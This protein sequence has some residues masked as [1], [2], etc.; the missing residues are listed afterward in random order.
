[1]NSEKAQFNVGYKI[2]LAFYIFEGIVAMAMGLIFERMHIFA[3][4]GIGV[5]LVLSVVFLCSYLKCPKL[6]VTAYGI[7]QNIFFV[8][9]NVFFSIS[10]D[11]AQVFLYAM[12]LNTILSFVF[13]NNTLSRFQLIQSI[14]MVIASAA[15]V[16]IYT[17]SQQ[18]MLVFTFGSILLLVMNWVVMSMTIYIN[19]QYRKG[20]EQERSLDDMLKLVEAKCDD[21]Q[22][23]TR[24]KSQFL[25]NM[26]HEIRT[27]INA[28]MG[29]NEMILR[30]SKEPGIRNYASETMTAAEALLEIINDIL[31]IT[32][33]ET[34]KLV[35]YPNEYSVQSLINDIYNLIQF[36]AYNKE[37]ELNFIIDENIP[38]KLIGD[39]IRLK[40]VIMNL[41]SNA[42][43]YTHTG[44][45]TFEAKYLG[46]GKLSFSVK[47]TGIGIKREDINRLF[48]AFERF[49]QNKNR[50][51]EG[52]GLGLNIA[53]SLLKMFG[54]KLNVISK[55]G[56][57]SIFSFEISQEI[58]DPTPVGK[59]K[60]KTRESGRKAYFTKF[61]APDAKILV[62][63]DN[64]MNRKVFINLLK[65]TKISI[66][67]AESG[68]ECLSMVQKNVYDII[69][70]DH[71]MPEMDGIQ[72]FDAMKEMDNN[73]SKDAPVFILTANAV[74]GAK[75][76]YIE[77]GFDGYLS[78]PVD[79]EKLEKMVISVLG[80][81]DEVYQSEAE[82]GEPK[83]D[84]FDEE[85]PIITGVDWN[86]AKLHFKGK[87]P[88]F[89]AIDMFYKSIKRDADELG[90]YFDAINNEGGISSYRIKVHSMKSS[91]ALIGIIHLA[92][93]ALELE[94]A[95]KKG[96]A[97]LI[98]LLHPV[99][100]QRWLGYTELL[101]ELI[102]EK[103][104]GRNAADYRDEILEI[105][106]CIRN[107][108]EEM[109]V[110]ILDEMSAKLDE[111]SFEGDMAQKIQD[112]KT[113]IFNFEIEKLRDIQYD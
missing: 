82:T 100:I 63:D 73:L 9:M 61:E 38:S 17:G 22:Q 64:R 44:S 62:V 113:C 112:I 42:V 37:L 24:S 58:A 4:I 78:K 15:F 50:G 54:S 18:T 74:V 77:K 16:G 109:D 43:K 106:E 103:A 7:V 13:I 65:E 28:I 30:E 3:V 34:G 104:P 92:G 111:Y 27:P 46:N 36:R 21:A 98:R 97:D 39:D 81:G 96:D 56:V 51:I 11:S 26:S 60:L 79:P 70:M 45:V 25:A 2:N 72:T 86:F 14:I 52:T 31:D 59:F 57:G 29:M 20:Y 99:F 40:Q 87:E 68:M 90:M 12:C 33:I 67:E 66:D 10:F 101:S 41:L 110:D 84:D 88:L 85:L 8:I 89:N 75:E 69:F 91:A 49:E 48:E 105:F 93:L 76:F 19:F 108:A 47:D 32:K 35:L 80:K 6:N 83:A 107:G 55:Y 53:S 1:M 94:N 5:L 23:A 95:A 102:Q 71:M